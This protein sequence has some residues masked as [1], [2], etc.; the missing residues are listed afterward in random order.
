MKKIRIPRRP[1]RLP[2]KAKFARDARPFGSGERY[3]SPD[4]G[5]VPLLLLCMLG[6]VILTAA[7]MLLGKL[8]KVTAVSAEDGTYYTAAAVLAHS[9][10]VQN[11]CNRIA[12]GIDMDIAVEIADQLTGH[13]SHNKR[14]KKEGH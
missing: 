10:I 2:F 11:D 3:T 14:A 8:P 5:S 4:L 7:V 9:D 6:V 1:K 13:R 12:V